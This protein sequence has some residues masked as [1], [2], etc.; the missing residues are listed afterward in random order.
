MSKHL[1][2]EMTRCITGSVSLFWESFFKHNGF[3]HH[4]PAVTYFYHTSN[5]FICPLPGN[6]FKELSRSCY[7]ELRPLTSGDP[8]GQREGV[9]GS[10]PVLVAPQHRVGR[11]GSRGA[12]AVGG[13]ARLVTA[14]VFGL[15]VDNDEH[16]DNR[17]TT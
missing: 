16:V 17:S 11:Q 9:R 10:D 14:P 15:P 1:S 4:Q 7:G 3:F 6:G 5:P 2:H 13:L 12:R 8:S